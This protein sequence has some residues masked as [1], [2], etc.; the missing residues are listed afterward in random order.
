MKDAWHS[1]L[2]PAAIANLLYHLNIVHRA[3]LQPLGLEKPA[4]PAKL[5]KP[6]G[7][8]RLDTGNRRVN[9]VGRHDIMLGRVYKDLLLPGK[10]LAGYRVYVAYILYHVTE[11]FEANRKGLVRRM[12]LNHVS[13]H[14]ERAPLKINVVPRILQVGK[15]AKQF[16]SVYAIAAPNDYHTGLIILRR[17]QPENTRNRRNN[18]TIFPCRKTRGGG[19]TQPVKVGVL[20]CV[21]FYVYVT[22]RDISFRLV[23]V[24]IAH[25]I[26]DGIIRKKLFELFV[27]LCRQRLI[28]RYHK[29]RQVK[30]GDGMSH[31]ERLAGAGNSHQGLESFA[32]AQTFY[33]PL[34]GLRLVTRR[35]IRTFQ[36]EYSHDFAPQCGF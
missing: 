20:R 28:V 11:E 25:E 3:G 21:L 29:H 7:K 6:F 22:L 1:F 33:E 18:D 5:S 10:L 9:P 26:L 8:L 13:A 14:P 12:K 17:A 27:Q 35:R 23:I 36:L 24:V 31:C 34:N 32:A 19:K 2:N 15:P 4:R 30:S 16:I